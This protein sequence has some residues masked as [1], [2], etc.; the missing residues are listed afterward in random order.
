MVVSEMFVKLTVVPLRH[1]THAL[2]TVVF[3]PTLVMSRVDVI[4]SDLY[5]ARSRQCGTW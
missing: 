3:S 1:S 2:R 5:C 4:T